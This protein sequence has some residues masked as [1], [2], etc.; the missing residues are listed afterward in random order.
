M[1]KAFLSILLAS[2]T[3]AGAATLTIDNFSESQNVG[4]MS[5]SSFPDPSVQTLANGAVRELIIGGYSSSMVNLS[6]GSAWVSSS[7]SERYTIGIDYTFET[8]LNLLLEGADKTNI[9]LNLHFVT[10]VSSSVLVTFTDSNYLNA[11]WSFDTMGASSGLRSSSL[12]SISS[13]FDWS[14]VNGIDISYSTQNG[15]NVILGQDNLGFRVESVPSVPEPS[16]HGMLLG[17]LALVAVT[18]RRRK[19]FNA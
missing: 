6:V 18:I 19:K 7:S 10:S 3:S 15:G 11:Y 1:K 2:A 8:P 5:G 12:N 14:A 13:T 9:T 17:G 16:T 4:R